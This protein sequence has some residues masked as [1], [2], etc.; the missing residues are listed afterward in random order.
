MAEEKMEGKGA[1]EGEREGNMLIFS[2]LLNIYYDYELN[3]S[4]ALGDAI[5]RERWRV[6]VSAP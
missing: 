1:G 2:I 5:I 3:Y 4:V 6:D